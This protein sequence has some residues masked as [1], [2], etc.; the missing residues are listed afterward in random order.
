[1]VIKIT[2]N[3]DVT[4]CSLSDIYSSALKVEAGRVSE[5]CVNTYQTTWRHI[6]EDNLHSCRNENRKAQRE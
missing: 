4:S 6:R 3:W 5:T 2:V 1:M